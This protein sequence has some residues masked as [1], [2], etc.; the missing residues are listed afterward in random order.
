MKEIQDRI[1]NEADRKKRDRALRR[2]RKKE[3]NLNLEIGEA[4]L[5]S[6]DL[7]KR[8][9]IL[10]RDAVKTLEFGKKVG[11]EAEGDSMQVVRDM[12]RL[13]LG[14]EVKWSVVRRMLRSHE[15]EMA[16][17]QETKLDSFNLRDARKLW[18]EDEVE[19][20]FSPARGRSGGLISLWNKNLFTLGSFAIHQ[21]YISLIGKWQTIDIEAEMIN[22]YAPND[23]AEQV[24]LWED[25]KERKIQSSGDWIIGGDFNTVCQK[26]ERSGCVNPLLGNLRSI[27]LITIS[28]SLWNLWK[29]RNELIFDKKIPHLDDLIFFSKL[30]ALFW[31]KA[32]MLKGQ[33]DDSS[34]WS[35]PTLSLNFSLPQSVEHIA[36][37]DETAKLVVDGAASYQKAGC[38]GYLKEVSGNIRCIF[39]CPLDALGSEYAE[40]MAIFIGLTLVCEAKWFGHQ[41]IVVES[42]AKVVLGWISTKEQRP[43]RWWKIFYELDCII[44]QKKHI[45]FQ[46]I[47]RESN[48][49]ADFLAKSSLQRNA[50]FKAWW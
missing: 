10:F 19:F 4:S 8:R 30:R 28:A 49:M 5:S 15:V 45:S 2:I 31:I 18:G 23:V 50:P 14:N 33:L 32:T 38:G 24:I 21:R 1:L 40:L 42:D 39:S 34:W 22:V 3:K 26:N 36:T 25:L 35:D 11:F 48:R 47:S 46:Y 6:S 17:L 12:V 43:W 16:F 13:G 37:S 44:E 7:R 27:W 41:A 29:A 9:D 20:V